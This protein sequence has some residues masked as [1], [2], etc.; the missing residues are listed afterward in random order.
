MDSVTLSGS[1]DTVDSIESVGL[2]GSAVMRSGGDG[3][4]N[5]KRICGYSVGRH[6]VNTA[7]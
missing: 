3:N 4:A 5:H 7:L 2:N 6:I 1:C